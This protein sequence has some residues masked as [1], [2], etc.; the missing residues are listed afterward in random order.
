MSDDQ[1]R[2][3]RAHA[4]VDVVFDKPPDLR[5][6]C[7]ADECKDDDA[8]AHMVR[9]WI[10][11]IERAA[12]DP[13]S[14]VGGYH[15]TPSHPGDILP[16]R[17]GRYRVVRILGTGGMGTVFEGE[18]D[19]GTFRQ[20][21]AI[22]LMRPMMASRNEFV[23]RFDTEREILAALSH[24]N[25]AG[26]LDGDVTGDGVPYCVLEYVDGQPLTA[27]CDERSLNLQG[28]VALMRQVC[29]AVRHAHSRLI[30][31][32]DI[33]PSNVL[34][35]PDG[36][37]KLLDFGLAR[38]LGEGAEVTAISRPDGL[39]TAMTPE[40]AS[41]EQFRGEPLGVAT[42]VYS[43]GVMLCEVLTGHR[44][45]GA[46]RG[47]RTLYETVTMT[48]A[49]LAS[50][51]M[52]SET[53][54][55]YRSADVRGLRRAL[56][57]DLDSVVGRALARAPEERYRSIDALDAEL[58]R[59]LNG[60]PV[61]AHNGGRWYRA[62]KFVRRHRRAAVAGAIVAGTLV[63]FAVASRL[64][65]RELAL[66]AE[67]T[68]MERNAALDLSRMLLG[69]LEVSWPWD[70]GGATRSLHPLLDS[71][72]A[73]ILDPAAGLG[74]RYPSL[75]QSLASGYLGL[76]DYRQALTVEQRLLE[77]L[78]SRGASRDSLGQ[79][80]MRVSELL[81]QSGNTDAG[82]AMASR[83]IADLSATR[84]NL[85]TRLYIGRARGLRRRGR[86]AEA[87][88]SLDT[89]MRTLM[90]DSARTQL[91][92][93]NAWE[94]RAELA[95]DARD[96]VAAAEHFRRALALRLAAKAP[97]L[98]IGNSFGDLGKIALRQSDLRA[99]DT[100]ITLAIDRKAGVVGR[101]H[102]E[103]A[104][105]VA[106]L[107]QVRLR[108]GRAD[109]ALRLLDEAIASYQVVG[110]QSRIDGITRVR[111]SLRSAFRTARSRD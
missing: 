14:V 83:A 19:D 40:Y 30:V 24:P 99:A 59:Y 1:L 48:D 81:R 44:P 27:W 47:W 96:L 94:V 85:V 9:Q 42:D 90:R 52:L 31:H 72:A 37:V 71:A 61:V 36:V 86:S 50:S 101:N 17:I 45:Y 92:Q 102:P 8:L 57:G 80:R 91:T 43:L 69:F 56:R 68:R 77:L 51:A 18:R 98:E 93:A 2:W 63:A 97:A 74:A 34:V 95:L 62:I 10:A 33:K 12:S 35:T 15:L 104:D 38:L 55:A 58:A 87:S 16:E 60:L 67:Q 109:D 106:S 84:P 49:P 6:A 20:R 65:T 53:D 105:E 29:E 75:L 70:S 110:R 54:A 39:P 88:A 5:A 11:G 41:P 64:H 25:I 13:S 108:Q 32:R 26:L 100:L 21:V 66:A 7:I 23:A 107:A 4:I 103:V 46:A 76:G 3:S 82:L 78:E 79:A 73:R 28:R 89:A 111:D 22:K